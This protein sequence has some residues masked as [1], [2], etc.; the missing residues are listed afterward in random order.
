M[1]F[2]NIDLQQYHQ[3]DDYDDYEVS[4]FWLFGRTREEG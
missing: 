2:V 3:H 4:W 1:D